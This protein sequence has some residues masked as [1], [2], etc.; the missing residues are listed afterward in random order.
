M[1][2]IFL[3]LFVAAIWFTSSAQH[4]AKKSAKLPEPYA[5][6]SVIKCRKEKGWNNG[7]TL[8]AQKGFNVT[9]YATKLENPRLTSAPPNGYFFITK[10]NSNF[11]FFQP[12]EHTSQ[13]N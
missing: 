11:I 1:T 8:G 7:Q 6:K 2:K 9:A 10:N 12:K 3:I 5:S 4:A 13:L